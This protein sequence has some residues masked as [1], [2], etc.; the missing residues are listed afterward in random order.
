METRKDKGLF[1]EKQAQDWLKKKGLIPV[2][3]N[4]SCRYGEIDLIMLDDRT[5]CFIE[6]KF[7]KNNAF[8]GTAYSIPPAKQKKII[9]SALIFIS[10]HKKFQQHALRFDAFFIQTVK[11]KS[12]YQIEWLQNAFAADSF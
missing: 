2:R 1:Y 6:V 11:N 9:Q 4:F 8:G 3:K 10:Q 7:R 12:Q 5:L